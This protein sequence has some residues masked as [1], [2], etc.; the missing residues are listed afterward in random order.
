MSANRRPR[1]RSPLTSLREL[2]GEFPRVVLV[3]AAGDLLASFGFSLFF[4][5][6]TIYLVQS[7]G[8]SAAEAGLVIAAY[9]LFSVVS[10]MAGGWLADR[11]GRRPVLIGSVSMT[12]VLVASMALV[13]EAWH[14]GLVMVLLG[15]VDPAFLPAARAAVADSVEEAGRPRA[16]A[17]L[18]VV[19]AIG[20]IA[21]PVIGA[22]LS[23]FGYPLLFGIS[24]ILVGSY[25]VVAVRWLPETRPARPTSPEEWPDAGSAAANGIEPR[26]PGA[27]ARRRVF[28]AF[29]PLLGV[30]HAL[31]F[32]WIT[33]LPIFAATTLRLATPVWGVLFGINGLLIVLF[34]MRI[35]ATAERHAKPALMA[36]ATLLYAA[37]LGLV[38]L[39]EP[40][41][42]VAGLAATITLVTAGEMLLMPVVPAFIAELSPVERRGTYQGIALAAS[43]VGSG[44]GP[45]LAGLVLDLA[46]GRTLWMA[47]AA[48]LVAVSLG[49][50]LLGRYAAR[51]LRHQEAPPADLAGVPGPALR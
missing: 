40:A 46:P 45:P 48:L 11:V 19:N 35:S 49:F 20:W 9:S 14:V 51:H 7:L 47:V 26:D 4:P 3:L 36:M 27:A 15:C 31:T 39:L 10:G 50:V 43:S 38:V 17:L 5:F 44:V 42:A 13:G 41:T 28:V 8:A 22:G 29:L 30:T 34:Q 25:T 32:L 2:L 23:S 18:G 21:G 12:A 37:G 24:G 6:L 33:T 1:L 16:F